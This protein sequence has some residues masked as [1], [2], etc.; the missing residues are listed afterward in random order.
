MPKIIPALREAILDSVQS[1]VATEGWDAL[2]IRTIAQRCGVAPG[3]IYNY[4]PS[5]E[6]I[7]AAVMGRD[8]RDREKRLHVRLSASSPEAPNDQREEVIACLRALYDELKGFAARYRRVWH[9]GGE[10]VLAAE[11]GR[12][13]ADRVRFRETIAEF[14]LRALGPIAE[15]TG[16]EPNALARF[17]SRAILD[18]A[19]DPK[20]RFDDALPIFMKILTPTTIR[21][22]GAEFTTESASRKAKRKNDEH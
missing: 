9:E 6:A 15:Q 4:F 7:A 18:L 22:I 14:A 8:W 1:A 17:L 19:L 3:T 20:C 5:R 10:S 16:I 2:A 21:P 12:A 13:D 11:S